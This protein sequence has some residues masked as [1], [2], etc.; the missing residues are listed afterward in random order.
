MLKNFPETGFSF[1]NYL[2]QGNTHSHISQG[3]R[4]KYQPDAKIDERHD[5][6]GSPQAIMDA[7][8]AQSTPKEEKQKG[9]EKFHELAI[10]NATVDP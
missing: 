4:L 6:R 3:C 5:S 2:E 10:C 9:K 8:A 1:L 7:A